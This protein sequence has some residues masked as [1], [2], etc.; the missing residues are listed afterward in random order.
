LFNS[1]VKADSRRKRPEEEGVMRFYRAL[2][3]AYPASF[4]AEYGEEM[5]GIFAQRL[6]QSGFFVVVLLWIESAIEILTNALA[7]HFDILRQDLIYA[8]RSF[9]RAPGFTVT[10][11]VVAALGIG[12]TTSAFTMVDHVL[13]R[14]LGYAEPD[15]IVKLY[16]DHSFSAGKN[17]NEWDVAPAQYRDW[18]AMSKSFERLGVYA[19]VSMNLVDQGDPQRVSGASVTADIFPALGVTP[20]MGRYFSDEDDRETAAGTVVL[21]DALWQSTFAGD[22]AVLGRKLVLDDGVYTVIGVMPKDFYFPNRDAQMWTAM[23]FPAGIFEN[24]NNNYV[25]GV[26]KLKRGVSIHQA[27]AEMNTIAGQ[28]SAANPKELAHV[29]ATV[30]RLQDDISSQSTMMLFVLLGAALC[31]LLVACTNLANLLLARAMTRRKELAV[32]A[33]MGAGRERLVRQMLTESLMLSIAGGALGVFLATMSLPLLTKLVPVYL[34]IAEVPVVDLRVLTMALAITLATGIGFGVLP[35]LRVCRS[36]DSSG[37]RD[38]ARSGGGRREGLRSILVIAEVSLSVVLLVSCGLLIRALLKIQAVD[39]GFKAENV[40]TMRTALPMPKY[41]KVSTRDQFYQTVLGQAQR[42]PGVVGAAY[43]SFLPIANGG[44]VW[45]V[46]AEGHPQDLSSRQNAS[47]RFITP[48]FL[49]TMGTPMRMGRNVS[50]EDTVTAPLVAV[51]SESFVRRYWPGENPIG[52]RFNFGGTDRIVVGVAGDVRVRGLERTDSEPQVYMPYKQHQNSTGYAPKDLVVRGNASVASLA[53]SLRRIVHETDPAEPV[54][55][56]R[57]MADIVES[58]TSSRRIQVDVLGAFAGI[59]FLLAAIGIHGV[60]AFAVSNRTQEIGVRMA[61]G[62]G[63]GDILSMI[64]GEGTI[65]AGAGVVVGVGLAYGAARGLQ[66][67]LAGVAP[68]DIATFSAAIGLC[69]VMTLVGSFAPAMRA[70][71]I[72]PV[73]AIRSE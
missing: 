33:A 8:A 54:T 20:A 53:P 58:S 30:I 18:K 19:G 4:R 38:S 28:L 66:T 46:E 52:R 26:A 43:T 57:M 72:D 5:C 48:G 15:R 9:R 51:V 6:A 40:L 23:R 17:G 13:I 44:G 63:S 31:V 67:L 21:S 3:H 70:V 29:G 7:V 27:A 22:R 34:P 37:L 12:A 25:Y 68:G 59:A 24:R 42:L 11:I 71:R 1:R 45:P 65:L 35:A 39:P 47:A 61:L 62:A 36:K 50:E 69:L 16:E 32:R 73:T 55:S 49:A 2:L 56:V 64:L 10:A 41:E 14:P 60:L